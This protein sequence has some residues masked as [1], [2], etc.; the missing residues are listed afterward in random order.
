MRQKYPF[1]V[2]I[3]RVVSLYHNYP[4]F[5]SI[6]PRASI[7]SDTILVRTSN[8]NYTAN[9]YEQLF[10]DAGF[11]NGYTQ[12]LDSERGIDFSAPNV[13]TYCFYSSGIPTPLTFLYSNGLNVPPMVI[14]AGD[15]DGRIN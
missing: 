15:G 8:R 14:A 1:E 9:E 11:P 3:P 13:S 5:Y 7:W 4:S 2:T 12:F 6:L 10:A